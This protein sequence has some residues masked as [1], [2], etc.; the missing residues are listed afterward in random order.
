[1]T[2]HLYI[3]RHAEAENAAEDHERPLSVTGQK[4]AAD[5]GKAMARKNYAPQ[6][7]YCSTARRTQETFA[8]LRINTATKYESRL[9]NGMAGSGDIDDYASLIQSTPETCERLLIIGHNPTVQMLCYALSNRDIK[10]I[11]YPVGQ[12]AVFEVAGAWQ[13]IAIESCKLLDII[14]PE[15]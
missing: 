6:L 14:T 4:Q 10:F 9:Y 2:K 3:L 15:N 5:M 7:V 1:M 12:L 13:D 11:S 8:G